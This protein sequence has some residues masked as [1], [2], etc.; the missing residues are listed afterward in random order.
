MRLERRTASSLIFLLA[1]AVTAICSGEAWAGSGL[2]VGVRVHEEFN[3]SRTP[4]VRQVQTC[5]TTDVNGMMTMGL[6]SQP[7]EAE[8]PSFGTPGNTPG[9]PARLPAQAV[10]N[11]T[12]GTSP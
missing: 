7:A 2:S 12:K 6:C 11:P 9:A 1:M 10:P 4:E 3:V 5:F 8:R